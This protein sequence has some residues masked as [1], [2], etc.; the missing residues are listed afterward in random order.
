[1]KMLNIKKMRPMYTNILVT[2][3][4]YGNEDV[5]K[6]GLIDTDKDEGAVKEYQTVLA[7]G[8]AVRNI[9]VGDMVAINPSRFAVKQFKD[10]SLNDGVIQQNPIIGYNFPIILIDNKECMLI[11]EKDIMYVIEEMEETEVEDTPIIDD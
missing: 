9:V 5:E 10:G 6:N 11:D 1:M 2:C 4:K 3:D 8:N 7:T